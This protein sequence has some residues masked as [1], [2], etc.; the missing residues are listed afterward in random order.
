MD[1]RHVGLIQEGFDLAVRVGGHNGLAALGLIARKLYSEKLIFVASQDYIR[2]H[3]QP[4]S[5]EAV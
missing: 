4:V 3:G 5:L 2:Q 1:N